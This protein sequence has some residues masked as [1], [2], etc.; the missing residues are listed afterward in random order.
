MNTPWPLSFDVYHTGLNAPKIGAF[1]LA[2]L[3]HFL[4]KPHTVPPGDG[5]I[6]LLRGLKSDL[7][8]C[9]RYVDSMAPEKRPKG[10]KMWQATIRKVFTKLVNNLEG[11]PRYRQFFGLSPFP[12]SLSL[13]SAS[14]SMG[15]ATMSSITS[16]TSSS[17]DALS[18]L[19]AAPL[20]S[21]DVEIAHLRRD[22]AIEDEELVGGEGAEEERPRWDRWA[23]E[24]NEKVKGF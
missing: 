3:S 14:L 10:S 21:I 13:G 2:L 24:L 5:G 20:S 8:V 19:D 12:Y 23:A 18:A 9:L 11:S 22:V 7:D 16:P 4:R 15:T 17:A 6:S 1:H